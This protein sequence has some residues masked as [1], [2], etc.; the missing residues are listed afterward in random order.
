M[1]HMKHAF[2]YFTTLSNVS[3]ETIF[4]NINIPTAAVS[5]KYFSFV[6]NNFEI[7]FFSPNIIPKIILIKKFLE[8]KKYSNNNYII[9][10]I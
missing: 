2:A 1:F 5:T 4:G 10:I 6:I 3:C 8:S 7:P 9:Y